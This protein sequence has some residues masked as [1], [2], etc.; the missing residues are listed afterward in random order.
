[1]G[2]STLLTIP[3]AVSAAAVYS[4][5]NFRLASEL[6][7]SELSVAP[8][9]DRRPMV[10]VRLGQVPESLPGARAPFKGLQAAG[11]DALL[12]LPEVGRFL[13]SDGEAITLDP[14]PAA[15]ERTLRLFLLGTALGILCH[16]RGLLPLHANAIV[17][18]NGAFAFSGPSGAG[19]S[20]LAAEFQRRGYRMLAD[21]VCMVDFDAAGSAVAWPGIPRLKLWADAADRF[22]LDCA[23]LDRV[24]EDAPK[25]HVPAA[26]SPDLG[27]APLRRLYFL[28][29][30]D[31]D[32]PPGIRRLK[33]QEA[34][35]AVMANTYRGFCLEPM[36]LG[37]R[38]FRQCADL[39]SSTRVYAAGR[40]WGFD[41]F[42]T[43]VDRLEQHLFE[44]DPE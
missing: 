22:G 7:L 6:A 10:M 2:E 30:A 27:P 23:A 31:D 34:M 14:D 8:A 32:N 39:L 13:V 29:R 3:Q 17:A 35:A 12:T 5:F 16:Q 42:E 11:N 37:A 26:V 20:T 25:Y 44:E 38:H 41:C 33:G 24:L 40:Q 4:C 43:E 21:D 18:G 1:M 9:G 15:S 28:S 36:G 19:K